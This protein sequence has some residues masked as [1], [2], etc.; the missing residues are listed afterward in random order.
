[1]AKKVGA[2]KPGKKEK[3]LVSYLAKSDSHKTSLDAYLECPASIFLTHVCDARDAYVHC[4][5]KF[6]KKADGTY[7]KNSNDSLRHISCSILATMM[8]HFE[9]YEKCL[10]AGL[11]ELTR[12]L[13]NFK[14]QE[15]ISKIE[16]SNEV[17]ISAVRLAAYRGIDA[18]VGLVIAD[19]LNGWH[20]PTKVNYYFSAFG[21]NQE[22]FSNKSINE[23]SVVWQLRHSVVHTGA[24]LTRPDAQKV[25]A[26]S[27]LGDRPIVFEH[28][29]IE[30]LSK[31]FHKIVAASNGRLETEF[32]TLLGSGAPGKAIKDTERFLKVSSP[33]PTWL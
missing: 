13:P 6:T 17:A 25:P 12:F 24:W 33:T 1:M 29:F 27:K 7:N 20:S 18:P 23:I 30:A 2:K 31:R 32:M 28:T 19:S 3:A 14:L 5:N 15:F 26:L 21:I 16:K 8:G 4:K 9:T 10:F 22:F 11:F